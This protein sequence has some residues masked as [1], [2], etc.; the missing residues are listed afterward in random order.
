MYFLLAASCEVTR[1]E[2]LVTILAVYQWHSCW[3]HSLKA[4]GA[5]S[6]DIGV[7]K[8]DYQGDLNQWAHAKSVQ[9]AKGAQLRLSTTVSDV[10]CCIVGGQMHR[11]QE[12]LEISQAGKVSAECILR[13][14]VNWPGYWFVL[15]VHL[16]LHF[17]FVWTQDYQHII[18]P[19]SQ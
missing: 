4:V 10:Y 7:W 12:A 3:N 1:S 14:I 13:E 2:G 18:A 15:V 9:L 6:G 11:K 17:T 19:T 5:L 16:K 8:Q